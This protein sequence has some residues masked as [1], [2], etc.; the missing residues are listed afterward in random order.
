MFEKITDYINEAA[1]AYMAVSGESFCTSAWNGFLLHVKHLL[2]FKFANLI[3]TI[4]IFIGKL[5]LT[6]GNVYTYIFI[7]KTVSHDHKEISS[8]LG[9]CLVVGG[10]TYMTASV[11]LGIIE[12]A[13]VALMTSMAIDM[14]LNGSNLKYGPPTFHDC[15][16][17]ILNDTSTLKAQRNEKLNQHIDQRSNTLA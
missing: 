16:S 4:F 11:L 8:L 7:M 17:R 2:K 14:D 9:P 15:M 12:T 3:A 10:F 5:G 6:A 13:V 1:F